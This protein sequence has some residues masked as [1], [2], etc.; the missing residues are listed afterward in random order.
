MIG[1]DEAW[2]S[3]WRAKVNKEAYDAAAK[4]NARCRRKRRQ[5]KGRRGVQLHG[6]E[7]NKTQRSTVVYGLM[8]TT[9]PTAT[10]GTAAPASD[11]GAF[12][13]LSTRR[14]AAI[15]AS[16]S[17]A[18][19]L[20]VDAA[21]QVPAAGEVNIK[22]NQKH[23]R[24][25]NPETVHQSYSGGLGRKQESDAPNFAPS[26]PLS[27]PRVLKPSAE[28]V[29]KRRGPGRPRTVSLRP[30]EFAHLQPNLIDGMRHCSNCGIPGS[31]GEGQQ[32][33]GEEGAG[34][35]PRRV[36]NGLASNK[37]NKSSLDDL[38]FQEVG[39]PSD[40]DSEESEIDGRQL[41]HGA[42]QLECSRHASLGLNVGHHLQLD[43]AQYP[44]WTY[45]GAHEIC[46]DAC[47]A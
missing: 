46:W 16:Q 3:T 7:P 26:A 35:L 23:V 15:A 45:S 43:C 31:L 12:S 30:P 17:L 34:N 28:N 13:G 4:E 47:A 41:A 6:R 44:S 40:S 39:S 25:V 9:A 38:S 29:E 27:S 5:T 42:V 1:D 10:R 19:G 18:T 33:G 21:G 32:G 11:F 2:W 8:A 20:S 37:A 14:T 24:P 22:L 36:A